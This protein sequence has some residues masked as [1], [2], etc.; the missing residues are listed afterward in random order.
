MSCDDPAGVPA[1][2]GAPENLVHPKDSALTPPVRVTPLG[3]AVIRDQLARLPGTPGVYRM[4]GADGEVL[5]VGKARNL[6]ARVSSYAAGRGHSNRITR[7]ISLTAGMEFVTTATETEALL[8]EANLIKRLRPRFN[9][10]MR[11]DKSFPYILIR[12]SG[13][14]APQ[15]VK[16][17]GA[18]SEKGRYYGPFASSWAVNQALTTLQKAFLLRSCSDSIYNGRTRPCMLHQI[19]RCAGPCAGGI[20]RADYDALVADAGLFLGGR[21][22]ALQDRLADEMHAAAEAMEFERAARLRDR[23][24]ALAAIRTAQGVN[25]KSFEEADVFAIHMENGFSCIQVFF[26]RAGQNWGNRAYFPRHERDVG[27]AEVL[28]AFVAQFYDDKP[29]P[30]LI[31]L[32][33]E[34]EG[35]ALVADALS[36]R[37]GSRIEV[38]TPQRGEKKEVVARAVQNA[39]EA[40]VRRMAESANQSRLLQALADAFDLAAPPERVE[41]YDNSHIMGTN[42]VGAMIVAGADGFTKGQ[43][44]KWTIKEATPGDDFG[45][46]REVLRR[47]FRRLVRAQG[48]SAAG[49]EDGAEGPA[50]RGP[51]AGGTDFERDEV[52]WPDLVVI[53]GGAGQLSVALEV[54]AEMGLTPRDVPIV[55]IAKGVDRDAGRETFHMPG[56]PPFRLERNDP[57]LFFLQRLRD[58]AHRFAIGAHRARRAAEMVRNPLDEIEGI[59]PTRKRALLSRFGSAKGVAR[60]ALADLEQTP[61]INA[62]LARRIHDHFRPA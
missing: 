56:R 22:A 20:G 33:E 6:K 30:E 40:L 19:R 32:S 55:S 9:V 18:R 42:A 49:A 46:M 58:E 17:R 36:V 53:D 44:R 13:G 15:L 45:M 37:A 35:A 16:H 28:E 61:G 34:I 50:V 59:G 14:R 51:D 62:E 12:E 24:R 4:L 2:P 31:L 57:V 54:L 21:S 11:D 25:P 48:D 29:S 1:P 43:Y 38:R 60:A 47:R 3:A 41:V 27:A 10:L 7:M 26:F 23:I 39:R 5:Y 52:P 8:L